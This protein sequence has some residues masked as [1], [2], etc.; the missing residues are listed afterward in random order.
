MSRLPMVVVL[1]AVLTPAN[2][3][4]QAASATAPSNAVELL[5][6][7]AQHYAEAKSYR[8]EAVEERTST[9]DLRRDWEKKTMIA[10]E[11]SSGRYHYEGHSGFGSALRVSDGKTVWTYHVDAQQYTERPVAAEV[12]GRSRIIRMGEE[13]L[14]DAEDLRREL[15]SFASHLKSATR[16]PDATLSV[17]GREVSCYVVRVQTADMKRE[18]ANYS[19][20]RTYWIDKAHETILRTVEHAH[21]YLM[22]AAARIPMQEDG[23]TTYSVVELNG[24]VPAD[25]FMFEPAMNA[26]LVEKFP[27]PMNGGGPDLTGQQVPVLKLKS[28]EGKLVSL[29]SFRGKPLLLDI[30][31]TWCPPCV[32]ALPHLAKIY[33][34][35]KDK[36]LAVISIDQDEEAK[37][38]T[39][40]LAKHGYTWPNFH[41]DG[42]SVR[43][44]GPSGIPR[45]LLI[46]AQGK[47]VLDR[48]GVREDEL[49]AGIAKLGSEYAFLAQPQHAPCGLSK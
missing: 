23:T 21:T 22:F 45:T 37:T 44:L 38:A 10:A 42:Q 31:A 14:S 17:A 16:L 15:G 1:L 40:F 36:G 18:T 27:N 8:I 47:I 41:D 34:Q 3:F 24:S 32:E 4:P 39:D 9:N 5:K 30:W 46:D 28:A 20:Q 33:V 6:R 19:F 48:M 12:S 7:V 43:A 26:K 35:A 25:L 11:A 13:A 2:L 29:T 49:R